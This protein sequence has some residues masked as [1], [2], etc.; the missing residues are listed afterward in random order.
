MTFNL[1]AESNGDQTDLAV[2]EGLSH[3][4]DI[5][6]KGSEHSWTTIPTNLI[7]E[8]NSNRDPKL[9]FQLEVAEKVDNLKSMY[10]GESFENCDTPYVWGELPLPSYDQFKQIG[11]AENVVMNAC[12]DKSFISSHAVMKVI[13]VN[14]Y[15]LIEIYIQ[16]RAVIQNNLPLTIIIETPSS[17]AFSEKNYFGKKEVKSWMHRLEPLQE[18]DVL[19]YGPSISFSIR[20]EEDP[21]VGN[22]LLWND[23]ENVEIPLALG[24]FLKEPALFTYTSKNEPSNRSCIYLSEVSQDNILSSQLQSTPNSLLEK[25]NGSGIRTRRLSLYSRGCIID[26]TNQLLFSVWDSSSEKPKE[27]DSLLSARKENSRKDEYVTILQDSHSSIQIS[28]NYH[29]ASDTLRH[30]LPFQLDELTPS[31]GGI[32]S[33]NIMWDDNTASGYCAFRDNIDSS[34]NSL[35][36]HIIPEFLLTNNTGYEIEVTGS[37]LRGKQPCLL[38]KNDQLILLREE[39]KKLEIVLRNPLSNW[40]TDPIPIGQLQL[41]IINVRDTET[42]EVVGT[43]PIDISS[44]GRIA[45]ANIG[46]GTP[47]LI[48]LSMRRASRYDIFHMWHDDFIKVRCQTKEVQI[49]L[50]ELPKVKGPP[51]QIA[52]LTFEE[53]DIIYHRIFLFENH[54][55]AIKESEVE[56][57]SGCES[58]QH[59]KISLNVNRFSMTDTDPGKPSQEVFTSDPTNSK[60]MELS[61]YI[62]STENEDIFHIDMIDLNLWNENKKAIKVQV[63]TSDN[64]VYRFVGFVFNLVKCK[65]DSTKF[66]NEGGYNAMPKFRNADHYSMDDQSS[67]FN[68]ILKVKMIRVSPLDIKVNIKSSES[69]LECVTEIHPT[70]L[71]R[72]MRKIEVPFEMELQLSEFSAHDI[73]GYLGHIYDTTK[74]IYSSKLRYNTQNSMKKEDD[75]EKIPTSEEDFILS[76]LAPVIDLIPGLENNSAF[77]KIK[78]HV[79]YEFQ[80][81]FNLIDDTNSRAVLKESG[82]GSIMY[83]S[84][85]QIDKIEI[86]KEKEKKRPSL[87]KPSPSTRSLGMSTR[88]FFANFALAK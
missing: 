83:A 74:T 47:Q 9:L 25:K 80:S 76:D 10:L 45:R 61:I 85:T 52:L 28:E 62:R 12:S 84:T 72:F 69:Q 26:H 58:F 65:K 19:S 32:V 16:P 49:I 79:I 37:N 43:L 70:I 21:V 77:Q 38:S 6:K 13:L 57:Q 67:F 59:S 27:T 82:S 8:K 66:L 81:I 35:L 30:S 11:K 39:P 5:C 24:E 78:S 63:D 33:K 87:S 50:T 7:A 2:L 88:N 15:P 54:Y 68:P 36:I 17:N 18:L 34:L 1:S 51:I 40:T 86:P 14:D 3:G 46:I 42:K 48:G 22:K 56:A 60:F 75:T 55:G 53:V 4:I 31:S 64:F 44:G 71:K 41:S 29:E 23:D 20:F 73:Q